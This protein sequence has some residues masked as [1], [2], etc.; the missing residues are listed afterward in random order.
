[1]IKNKKDLQSKHRIIS[2][3]IEKYIPSTDRKKYL[4]MFT[5]TG[6]TIEVLNFFHPFKNYLLNTS[7]DYF[8]NVRK[9]TKRISAIIS[10]GNMFEKRTGVCLAYLDLKCFTLKYTELITSTLGFLAQSKPTYFMITDRGSFYYRFK[11]DTEK[12]YGAKKY[13]DYVNKII[14]IFGDVKYSIIDYKL[15]KNKNSAIYLFK[16]E[17][18]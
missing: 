4:E 1:M 10:N 2:E 7:L 9:K 6:D 5:E 11:G 13:V 16:R 12:V 14:S 15:F 18:E 17:G 3:F 8:N